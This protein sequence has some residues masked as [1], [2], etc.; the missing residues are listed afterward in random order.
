MANADLLPIVTESGKIH[1]SV[2]GIGTT[3]GVGLIQIDKPSATATVRKAIAVM[4][5][6]G[7]SGFNPSDGDVSIGGI[8]VNGV[9]TAGG[10]S[11]FF[12]NGWADITGSHGALF[13]AAPVGISDVSYSE[14]STIEGTTLA[15]VWDFPESTENET[16]VFYFGAQETTGD[17]FTINLLDPVDLGDPGYKL[18]FGLAISFSAQDQSGNAGSNLCGS[19]SAMNSLVDVN[20]N[21][22]SSSAGNCDDGDP[23]QLVANSNLFTVGGIG[24]STANPTDPNAQAPCPLPSFVEDELYTLL[25]FVNDGDTV[26]VVDTLNP[27]NDDNI[28]FAWLGT[29]G[30]AFGGDVAFEPPSPCGQKLTAFIDAPFS[31]DIV[32]SDTVGD[33]VT[34]TSTAIPAGSSH[35]PP[36]P[37]VGSPATTTFSW[38]PN[39]GDVGQYVIT[40]TADNQD[41]Q[42]DCEVTI[43]VALD[44]N[45]NGVADDDDIANG[46]SE[47]G[48][49]NGIPDECEALG[50]NYCGPGNPNSTGS[51]GT[52]LATG[53]DVAADMDLTL[54]ACNL[55]PGNV[56]LFIASANQGLIQPPRS[57]GNLCLMGPDIAR[58]KFDAAI[59]DDNGKC[60]LDVDPFV[61]LTNP[62]QPILAGQTWYFQ[63]W[64]RDA[65]AGPDCNN[66]FT[67]AVCITFQ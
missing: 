58:F 60:S 62:P 15:I 57:C 44:C 49:G 66:N 39:A 48:N 40:Y 55:P 7:F 13:N 21:R 22:I 35:A 18:D 29:T 56:C 8:A 53:S 2:D 26:I 64:H 19:D 59:V 36:L 45:D 24:D 14:V 30:I 11:A 20:G 63:A 17:Q 54:T 52:I 32:A 6:N 37:T 9:I 23:T 25:P 41:Q 4:A 31:Y 67:D 5:N 42:V 51:P 61:V 28:H 38:T 65:G 10:A 46:T 34:L 1:V 43:N 12:N 16:G 27:S 50:D 3:S 33:P 47:D